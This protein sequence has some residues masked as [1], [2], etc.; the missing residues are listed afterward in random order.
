MQ[1]D[2]AWCRRALAQLLYRRETLLAAYGARSF[3]NA[4]RARGGLLFGI[5]KTGA[6]RST[7]RLGGFAGPGTLVRQAGRERG[8]FAQPDRH[9]VTCRRRAD[10][11]ETIEINR[12]GG[13]HRR[14]TRRSY[15]ELEGRRAFRSDAF[16]TSRGRS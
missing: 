2:R 10:A 4:R 1:R 8:Q 6:R 7:A 5:R 14:R 3:E 16:S 9:R 15:D 12:G 13:G 11:Y